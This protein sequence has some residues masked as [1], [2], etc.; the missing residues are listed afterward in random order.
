M[1]RKLVVKNVHRD[2][3]KTLCV[4]SVKALQ[5]M[6]GDL[7]SLEYLAGPDLANDQLEAL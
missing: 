4:I 7:T 3:S 1:R 6:K 2:N 5:H